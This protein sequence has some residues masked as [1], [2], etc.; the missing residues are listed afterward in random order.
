MTSLYKTAIALFAALLLISMLRS[1]ELGT[2]DDGHLL[3]IAAPRH[4]KRVAAF[5]KWAAAIVQHF[6]GRRIIW[7]IQN[8]PNNESWSPKPDVREYTTL[9]LATVHAIRAVD[10]HATIVGASASMV[11]SGDMDWELNGSTVSLCTPI[12]WAIGR[13]KRLARSMQ[14]CAS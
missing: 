1:K 8:E 11:E 10:P 6:S 12:E 9:A 2:D 7:E 5:A 4:P 3:T 14:S 13:P